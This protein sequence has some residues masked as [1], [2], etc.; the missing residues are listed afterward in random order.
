MDHD[1]GLA[2][3]GPSKGTI[4]FRNVSKVFSL[5]FRESSLVFSGI[6]VMAKGQLK[7]LHSVI[8]EH[9]VHLKFYFLYK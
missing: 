8:P 9:I 1:R 6:L 2:A 7:V 3:A 4:P 5:D